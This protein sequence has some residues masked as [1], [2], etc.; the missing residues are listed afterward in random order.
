[1]KQKYCKNCLFFKPVHKETKECVL[2]KDFISKD[3]PA[4]RTF[5]LRRTNATDK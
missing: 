5:Q 3:S 1:M 4:C 2:F